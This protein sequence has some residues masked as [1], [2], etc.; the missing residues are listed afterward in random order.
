MFVDTMTIAYGFHATPF[1]EC[2]IGL[3][4]KGICYL[5]FAPQENH[6]AALEDLENEWPEATLEHNQSSTKAVIALIATSGTSTHDLQVH[7]KG[8]DFQIS[9][10]EALL[11]IPRGTTVSYEQIAKKIGNPAAVRAAAS[12]VAKNK[13]SLL[14]PCHRVIRKTGNIG[15][16][17]WGTALKKTIL[18]WESKNNTSTKK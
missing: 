11:T 15:N 12:A 2:L 14:I 3:S 7:L 8:T 9:V 6:R 5:S 13:I 17:R 4:D 16:Y 10:W 18:D 1:G